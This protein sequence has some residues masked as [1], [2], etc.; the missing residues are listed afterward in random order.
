MHTTGLSSSHH[1]AV[2]LP[3]LPG[4]LTELIDELFSPNLG[5]EFEDY[6]FNSSKRSVLT[7]R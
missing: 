6:A 4:T 5:A 7:S 2:F 3:S 1:G